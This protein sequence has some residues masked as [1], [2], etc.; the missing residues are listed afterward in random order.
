[1][2]QRPDE[3]SRWYVWG[4]HV[5]VIECFSDRGVAYVRTKRLRDGKKILPDVLSS[6]VQRAVPSQA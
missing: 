5:E 6:F 4:E 3:G 2:I 1:M